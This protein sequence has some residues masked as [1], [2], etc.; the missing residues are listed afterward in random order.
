MSTLRIPSAKFAVTF[1][2]GELPAVDPAD[3]RLSI[4][5]GGTTIEARVNRKAAARLSAH[6]GG[7]VL[8][9]RLIAGPNNTLVL[10]EAGF[11]FFESRPAAAS[12]GGKDH[13]ATEP[14]TEAH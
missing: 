10:A 1:P 2:A 6:R 8:L 7:A 14:R 9:G 4:S 5:L 11:T 3:P 12:Q 13:V